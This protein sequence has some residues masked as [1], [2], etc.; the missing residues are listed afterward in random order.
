MDVLDAV[1][2]ANMVSLG[3]TTNHRTKALQ[4]TQPESASDHIGLIDVRENTHLQ[5]NL[6]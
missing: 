2:G 1:P 4:R 5:Q 3:P 6:R